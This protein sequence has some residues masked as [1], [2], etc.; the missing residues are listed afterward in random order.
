MD[1]DDCAGCP[2]FGRCHVIPVFNASSDASM[3]DGSEVSAS[4]A[5]LIVLEFR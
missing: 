2:D 3:V 5:C 1:D 4:V